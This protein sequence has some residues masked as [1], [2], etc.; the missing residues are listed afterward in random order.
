[1]CIFKCA[2][3]TASSTGIAANPER[4]T[5]CHFVQQA[6]QLR[7]RRRAKAAAQPVAEYQRGNQKTK[8][9][10]EGP[11]GLPPINDNRVHPSTTS[12]LSRMLH[13][14]GC[15]HHSKCCSYSTVTRR[16]LSRLYRTSAWVQCISGVYA[17]PGLCTC[18]HDWVM[19]PDP[20][21]CTHCT[22]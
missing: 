13:T 3:V 6:P 15:A 14:G 20:C 4:F 18:S 7:P 1:M 9:R 16:P 12:G 8:K 22:A 19:N 11:P 21:V 17:C 5:N 2:E 10:T